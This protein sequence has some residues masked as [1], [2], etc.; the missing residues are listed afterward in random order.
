MSPEVKTIEGEKAYPIYVLSATWTQDGTHKD[1]Y[2]WKIKDL[3]AGR[4][5]NSISGVCLMERTERD[6]DELVCEW[7]DRIKAAQLKKIPSLDNFS[8][9]LVTMYYET[10]CLT[11]FCHHTFDD[12]RTDD[13]FI[14]SF[15]RYVDRHMWYQEHFSHY[16]QHPEDKPKQAPEHLIC[17][18]GAEDRW[19]WRASDE[20]SSIPCR[21][22]GC[23]KQGVVRISH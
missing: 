3:P 6:T 13:E 11:W 2:H 14:E 4:I 10:W 20:D 5:R 7:G 8:A 1:A 19:R 16:L 15:H 9:K 18:M 17:L 23:V 22:E 12:G 21:C